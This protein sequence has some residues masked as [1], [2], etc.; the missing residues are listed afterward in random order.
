MIDNLRGVKLVIFDYISSIPA[1]KFPIKELIDMARQN[2]VIGVVDAAHAIGISQLN[3]KDLD[4]DFF[5]S[6]LH[7][8]CYVP[9]S[10]SFLY[11]S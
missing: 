4:P 8:W 1:I 9:Q 6:N 7:K 10:C 2:N 3:I 11:I 5:F